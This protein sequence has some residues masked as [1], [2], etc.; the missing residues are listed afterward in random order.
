MWMASRT[1]LFHRLG[2]VS[3][4]I[5]PS[6]STWYCASHACTVIPL[7]VSPRFTA[8]LCLVILFFC[9]SY[10]SLTLQGSRTLHFF[11]GCGM[12][13]FTR[14]RESLSVLDDFNTALMSRCLYFLWISSERPLTY[15]SSSN[16][17]CLQ[18][19]PV[20]SFAERV[21]IRV[22]ICAKGFPEVLDFFRVVSL[23]ADLV[24]MV[25]EALQY[26]HGVVVR[27]NVQVLVGMSRQLTC[28]PFHLTR[29][30][31]QWISLLVS[32]SLVNLMNRC[33]WLMWLWNLLRSSSPRVHD[34]NVSIVYVLKPDLLFQLARREGLLLDGLHDQIGDNRREHMAVPCVCSEVSVTELEVCWLQAERCEVANVCGWDAHAVL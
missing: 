28:F 8:R 1:F 10:V 5:T 29:T 12:G 32:V 9:L 27:C 7:L 20:Y 22:A 6:Q 33:W 34:M 13:V 2:S 23:I 4:T 17:G 15:R 11:L 24:G 3:L 16:L 31:R 21:F 26:S 14:T 30:S 25:L 19:V 18:W